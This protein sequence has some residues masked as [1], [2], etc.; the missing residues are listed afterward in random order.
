MTLNN[1]I[2]RLCSFVHAK[3]CLTS[4]EDSCTKAKPLFW[5]VCLSLMRR[6]LFAERLA[7]GARAVKMASTVARGATFLKMIAVQVKSQ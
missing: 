3:E 6:M 5:P 4:G 7:Y 2:F 1:N